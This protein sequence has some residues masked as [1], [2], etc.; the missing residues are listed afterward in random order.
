MEQLERL[1]ERHDRAV[2]QYGLDSKE[3]RRIEAMM[4]VLETKD[5]TRG[6]ELEQPKKDVYSNIE[7]ALKSKREEA[8][9]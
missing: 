3:A 9:L 2:E 6:G 4:R 7:I 8:G 1:K 5:K